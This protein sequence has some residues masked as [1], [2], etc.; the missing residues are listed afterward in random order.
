VGNIGSFAAL[1]CPT[2]MMVIAASLLLCCHLEAGFCVAVIVVSCCSVGNEDSGGGKDCGGVGSVGGGLF[3][4]VLLSL[5]CVGTSI[6]VSF[7]SIL[8]LT[9]LIKILWGCLYIYCTVQYS[10]SLLVD[11]IS[12][13]NKT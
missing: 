12:S 4:G 7:T 5:S 13:P 6:V 2:T 9:R 10:N 11:I 3:V 1:L 8:F